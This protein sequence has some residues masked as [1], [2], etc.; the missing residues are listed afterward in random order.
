MTLLNTSGC[1]IPSSSTLNNAHIAGFFL[2]G[3]EDLDSINDTSILDVTFYL[4]EIKRF[5][6]Q[7]F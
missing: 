3:T 5:D 1:I 4:T 2:Y 6:K 7:L